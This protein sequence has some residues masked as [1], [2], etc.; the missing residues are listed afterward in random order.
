VKITFDLK[1]DKSNREKHGIS[2]AE[3]KNF[4]WDSVRIR[5][6]GRKDYGEIREIAL[7]VI[8]SRVYCAV[9]V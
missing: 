3:A 4:D 8:G 7:G 5:V 1:K 6:D 9:F 2:L